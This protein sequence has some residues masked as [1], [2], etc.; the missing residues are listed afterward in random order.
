MFASN[1]IGD[2]KLELIRYQHKMNWKFHIFIQNP[3]LVSISNQN[4]VTIT[5]SFLNTTNIR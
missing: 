5:P 3:S 2:V 4:I 1:E